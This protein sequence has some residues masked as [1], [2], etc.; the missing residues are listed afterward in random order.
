M[1]PQRLKEPT[2]LVIRRVERAVEELVARFREEPPASEPERYEAFFDSLQKLVRSLTRPLFTRRLISPFAIPRSEVINDSL[3]EAHEDARAVHAGQQALAEA[4]AR[5]FN[6]LQV[7]QGRLSGLLQKAD[8]RLA[9]YFVMSKNATSRRMTFTE[10]FVDSER[11]DK[12]SAHVDF[13]E[14]LVTLAITGSEDLATE[15]AIVRSDEEPAADPPYSMPGNWF[16]AYKPV[17]SRGDKAAKHV[18]GQESEADW[19]FYHDEDP[20][21]D[22]DACLDPSPD[23]WFEWQ[24][25]NVPE[26]AKRPNPPAP[27]PDTRGYGW[28][29]D[30]GTPIYYGDRDKHQLKLRLTVDLGEVKT[31]N[32]ISLQPYFPEGSHGYLIVDG[33]YTSEDGVS[34]LA[35]PDSKLQIGAQTNQALTGVLAELEHGNLVG[36][37]AWSFPQ[38]RCR[39]VRFLLR[40]P[41]SYPA[42]IGHLYYTVSYDLVTQTRI[43]FFKST[44][45][46]RKTERVEGPAFPRQAFMRRHEY[47]KTHALE[48][49]AAG[50]AA[51]MLFSMGPIAVV[52]GA[53]LG[54]LVSTKRWVENQSPPEPHWDIYTNGWRWVIG[55]KKIRI[56]R[57]TYARQSAITTKAFSIPQGVKA[58]SLSVVEEIP[59]EFYA[60]DLRTRNEWI[61]YYISADG[62]TWQRISPLEHMPVEDAPWYPK[63]YSGDPALPPG[64]GEGERGILQSDG[65]VTKLYVKIELLRPEG[66]EFEGMTPVLH[67]FTL[68]VVPRSE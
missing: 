6:I 38:R 34:F 48:G 42:T 53:L 39:Y 4:V 47:M 29:F 19:Q 63:V 52:V 17:L 67:A 59:E 46:E 66:R 35:V 44:K 41:Q 65:P 57:Y 9:D 24:M 1:F 23:T 10:R 60:K 25:I 2:N 58:V 27:Y 5:H 20:R 51:W 31:V 8:K 28:T 21:D 54:L 68:N 3:K 32:W 49:A 30:D 12:S 56:N 45:R 7:D 33:V 26:E 15:A 64:F 50:A 22:L 14:G 36:Q 37:G 55:V 61:R 62:N 11:I 40:S 18:S 13:Q 16:V 43:L